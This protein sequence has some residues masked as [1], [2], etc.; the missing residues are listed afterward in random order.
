MS[1]HLLLSLIGL[2]LPFAFL[3]ALSRVK[4]LAWVLLLSSAFLIYDGI[5]ELGGKRMKSLVAA[6][7]GLVLGLIPVLYSFNILP[8]TIPEAV[9]GV[10][11]YLIFMAIVGVFLVWDITGG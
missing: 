10:V 9:W 2:Q 8:F 11:L 6:L 1:L 7:V 3:V 4:V 5:T